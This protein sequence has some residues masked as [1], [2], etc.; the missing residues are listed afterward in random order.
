MHR[1]DFLKGT[2]LLSAALLCPTA[3]AQGET[4][5]FVLPKLDY[6]YNA[7]EPELDAKTM[8][9]HH[10]K[11]HAAYV[12]NLN[13]TLSSH[14]GA[15]SEWSLEELLTRIEDIPAK[16]RTAVQNHGGGHHN[17]LM[18]WETLAPGDVGASQ[19]FLRLVDEQL[20][21]MRCLEKALEKEAMGRFGSGWAWLVQS[22]EGE[23]KTMSTANQNSPI[24][25]GLRPILGID[26]WEH[27]YYLKFQNR[28]VDYFKAVWALINWNSVSQRL[29]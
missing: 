12:D 21:G 3:S 19:R 29:L 18:W 11:H 6:A 23:L 13:K 5:R 7:L 1:R 2:L 4:K 24:S 20:G 28:R 17:H 25:S 26:V 15:W 10:T 14:Q 8:E 16:I 22:A 9:I 27:A